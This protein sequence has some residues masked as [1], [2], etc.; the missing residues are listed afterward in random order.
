MY[1]KS[2]AEH[3]KDKIVHQKLL[4]VVKTAKIA[5][6]SPGTFIKLNFISKRNYLA[7]RKEYLRTLY[8]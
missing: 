6:I 1:K 5:H 8:Q 4:Y 2:N 3:I 7:L